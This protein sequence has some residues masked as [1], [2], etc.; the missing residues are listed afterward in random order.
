MPSR[1]SPSRPIKRRWIKSC[2]ELIADF[3]RVVTMQGVAEP[4]ADVFI[5]QWDAEVDSAGAWAIDVHLVPG[6]NRAG[7]TARDDAGNETE[8]EQGPDQ[9]QEQTEDPALAKGV[10]KRAVTEVITPNSP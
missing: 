1:S 10:V 3:S 2:T 6:E 5:G 8:P 9:D 4:G 7:V